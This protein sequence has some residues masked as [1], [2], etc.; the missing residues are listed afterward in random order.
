MKQKPKCK[1]CGA[2]L[3]STDSVFIHINRYDSRG[4]RSKQIWMCCKCWDNTL[5]TVPFEEGEY[6]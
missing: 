1:Y 5:I 6:L 2:P 4:R 3:S